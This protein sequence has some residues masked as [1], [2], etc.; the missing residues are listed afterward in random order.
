MFAYDDAVSE[1]SR[2]AVARD[3]IAYVKSQSA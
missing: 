3:Y 2:S 1:L